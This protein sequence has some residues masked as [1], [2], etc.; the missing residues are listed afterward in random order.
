MITA[1][2]WAGRTVVALATLAAFPAAAEVRS[3]EVRVPRAF[4]YFIGDAI[5]VT[6]EIDAGAEDRLDPATIPRPGPLAYWL[7]LTSISV[8]EREIGDRRRFVVRLGLQSFYSAL[9]PRALDIPGFEFRVL[10]PDGPSLATVPA[11]TVTLS[12][13]REIIPR[14]GD[15]GPRLQPD[16]SPVFRPARLAWLGFGG[17][18]ALAAAAL[19]AL[20]AERAWWPF[21]RRPSRP[22][23]RAAREIA[24]L[25]AGPEAERQ[26]LLV[27]HRAFDAAA[28]RR[29]LADDLPDFLAGA[30][31]LGAEEGAIAAFFARSRQVFFGTAAGGDATASAGLA[32]RLAAAERR[33]GSAA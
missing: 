33:R 30:P 27:L 29:L 17:S 3:V 4:G 13:L 28:G 22:F 7:E 19:A 14:D 1:A 18:L 24:R 20:A 11:W 9:E 25:P 26:G 5:P 23:A 10:G 12:P 31:H 8:E 15:A 32:R 16:A 6:V 21:H 2:A